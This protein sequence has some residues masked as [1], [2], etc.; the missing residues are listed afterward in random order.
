MCQCC[1]SRLSRAM[2]AGVCVPPFDSASSSIRRL[3]AFHTAKIIVIKNVALVIKGVVA[4]RG[5]FV[6]NK[7]GQSSHSTQESH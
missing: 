3:A 2:T 4:S 5:A 7:E 6:I 1:L